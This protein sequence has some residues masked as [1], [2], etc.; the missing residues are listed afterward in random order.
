LRFGLSNITSEVELYL[1]LISVFSLGENEEKTNTIQPP[2]CV[3]LTF[4]WNLE[5]WSVVLTL[6]SVTEKDMRKTC[7]VKAL[8]L[9]L[10]TTMLCYMIMVTT[11]NLTL[12][13]FLS[14]MEIL[15]NFLGGKPTSIAMSWV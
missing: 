14:S 6:N 10:G 3:F 4:N 7:L 1:L 11:R 2:S 12:E 5:P 9:D 8:L 15:K 13:K